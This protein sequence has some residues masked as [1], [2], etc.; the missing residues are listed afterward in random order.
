MTRWMETV[1]EA[2]V[3]PLASQSP[4]QLPARPRP[5][6]P[7]QPAQPALPAPPGRRPVTQPPPRAPGWQ[8]QSLGRPGRRRRTAARN[9]QRGNRSQ[10]PRARRRRPAACPPLHAARAHPPPHRPPLHP[11]AAPRPT[12][13]SPVHKPRPQLPRPRPAPS[14]PSA[15]P[16][17]RGHGEAGRRGCREAAPANEGASR[18]GGRG[19]GALSRSGPCENGGSECKAKFFCKPSAKAGGLRRRPPPGRAHSPRTPS[20][21]RLGPML[22]RPSARSRPPAPAPSASPVPVPPSAGA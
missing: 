6:R 5:R 9:P 4:A 16:A 3:G 8:D 22:S 21:E 10:R 15:A 13:G 18:A 17:N 19:T 20:P 11:A 1:P 14:L 2:G 12:P 7:A